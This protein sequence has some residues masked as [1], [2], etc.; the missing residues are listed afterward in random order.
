MYYFYAANKLGTF[1]GRI[2]Y[3]KDA[4]RILLRFPFGLGYQGW[5]YLQGVIQHGVYHV[6]FIHNDLLQLL[7]DYGIVAGVAVIY[8]IVYLWNHDGTEKLVCIVLLFHTLFDFDLQ[9]QYMLIL[10]TMGLTKGCIVYSGGN[11]KFRHLFAVLFSI[12]SVIYTIFV[13]ADSFFIGVT[14]NTEK[15]VN[16]MLK[17]QDIVAAASL[18]DTILAHNSYISVA[19]RV[20][21]EY[22]FTLNDYDGM[23]RSMH[24]Y[25]AI[26]KYQQEAYEAYWNMLVDAVEEGMDISDAERETEWL[27]ALQETV[28]NQ[29][30]SLA[31]QIKDKPELKPVLNLSLY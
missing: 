30:D 18:S 14:W 3:W 12:T 24:Q 20:K 21:G 2:L 6:R 28:I 7:V 13:C 8:L 25:V 5:N 10:L 31:W 4:I 9:F 27:R 29:T 19:W 23:C 17:C 22:E 26:E 16:D 15:T 11:G 1:Y